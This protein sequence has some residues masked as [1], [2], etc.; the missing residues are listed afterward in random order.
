MASYTSMMVVS[1]FQTQNPQA[2]CYYTSTMIMRITLV[3]ESH[4]KH[5]RV[6]I[7]GP[8][9]ARMSANVPH[10]ALNAFAISPIIKSQSVSCIPYQY[11]MNDF[12][13]LR[14]TL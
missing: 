14:W 10:L 5:Y 4:I 6:D 11:L 9:S 7:S 2:N 3:W 13:I 1:V 8:V 12:R